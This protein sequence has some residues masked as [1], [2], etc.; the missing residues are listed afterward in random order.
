MHARSARTR[1]LIAEWS[2]I[3]R[4]ARFIGGRGEI[5]RGAQYSEAC[6]GRQL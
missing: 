2:A 1:P 6:E 4:A 3:F 5:E